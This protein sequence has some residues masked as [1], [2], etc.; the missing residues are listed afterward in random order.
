MA[1]AF[2]IDP[3][4][5][6]INADALP[7]LWI[8]ILSLTQ[9][10]WDLCWYPRHFG[11]LTYEAGVWQNL[12]TFAGIDMG[13]ESFIRQVL[14]KHFLR[15]CRFSFTFIRNSA[16]LK[17]ET[18]GTDGY[19]SVWML[20]TKPRS[21]GKATSA[22]YSWA[23]SWVPVRKFFIQTVHMHSGHRCLWLKHLKDICISLSALIILLQLTLLP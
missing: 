9:G 5:I 1:H 17:P 3:S 12:T 21:S 23:I 11:R 15:I 8:E 6:G 22:L 16:V 18:E 10:S 2:A 7:G 14:C 13:C 19:K 20:G 4:G